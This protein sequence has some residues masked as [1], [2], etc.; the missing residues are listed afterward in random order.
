MKLNNIK[1]NIKSIRVK[2]FLTL[3][4]SVMSIILILILANNI[5]LKSFYTYYKSKTLI[6]VK[7]TINDYYNSNI[8]E[9]IMNE[10]LNKIAINNNFD[11][12]IQKDNYINVYTSNRAFGLSNIEINKI[13]D[14]VIDR[15]NIY[16]DDNNTIIKR[17]IDTKTEMKFILLS[18]KLDN[19]YNLYIKLPMQSIYNSVEISNSFLYLVGGIAIL[20]AGIIILII[21]RKFTNPILEL[22]DIAKKMAK[23]DFS[24]KFKE[25]DADDEINDLGRSIN[26]MSEKLEKVI[27]QLKAS[28]NDLEKDIE[29]KSKIDDMRKTFISD[30]SHELKTPIALIQ[31][32]SEGLIENVN[33]DEESRKYY[34]EVILDEANKMDKLV[35]QLLELSKLE[36]G[37]RE[38][39][40]TIFNINELINEVI[41]KTKVMIDEKNIKIDFQKEK[42][43]N[44]FADRFYIEQVITNYITNAIKNALE[45][46]GE[47]AVKIF[48]EEKKNNIRINVFNTGNKIDEDK[49]DKIWDRFYKQDTSRNREDGGSGIG[50]SLVKAIMNNYNNRYGVQN[51]DNGVLFY[52][53]LKKIKKENDEK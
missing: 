51:K 20:I 28:N 24:K 22:N 39:N 48:I 5:I 50:L 52:F 32:Y 11:I 47:K 49:I 12:Q 27:N 46:D 4:I 10:E 14:S 45:I 1:N 15:K 44:V 17:V 2:L 25:T 18:S 30:V 6:E 3:A 8:K 41:K 23:L 36:Y 33:E 43:I 13:L 35:K 31:G 7:D 53:E 21:S 40:N 16:Y 26:E 19:G 9:D 37:K 38:F 42:T 29:R 34:A